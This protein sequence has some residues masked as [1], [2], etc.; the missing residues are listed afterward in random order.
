MNVKL[1][2]ATFEAE[3][4]TLKTVKLPFWPVEIKERLDYDSGLGVVYLEGYRERLTYETGYAEGELPAV[5][6]GLICSITAYLIS[7]DKKFSDEVVTMLKVL[8]H[9]RAQEEIRRC[10]LS[11][12]TEQVS[13]IY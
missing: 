5:Y 4:L 6:K 11:S 1:R 3:C 12:P 2:K 10:Q 8:R 7:R 9:K 13:R